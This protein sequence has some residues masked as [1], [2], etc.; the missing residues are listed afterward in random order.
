MTV[1][2]CH[3]WPSKTVSNSLR[4]SLLV[5]VFDGHTW[6]S[7]TIKDCL[8]SSSHVTVFDDHIWP[9]L[10]VKDDPRLTSLVMIFDGHISPSWILYDGLRPS[11]IHHCLWRSYFIVT[12]RVH[13]W[14]SLTVRTQIAVK[15]IGS[16]L[17][18]G[19]QKYMNSE[20]CNFMTTRRN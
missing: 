10:T 2:D 9:S 19:G 11:W 12:D 18:F 20:G 16:G 6:Q 1:F 7:M 3:T 5:T 4:P 15:L 17:Y 13:T 8:R 14:R